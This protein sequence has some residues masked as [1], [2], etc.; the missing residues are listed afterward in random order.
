MPAIISGPIWVRP[1]VLG[2]TPPI[3]FNIMKRIFIGIPIE[4]E[5]QAE[6]LKLQEIIS[7]DLKKQDQA[8]QIR[9]VKPGNLHITLMPPWR[10]EERDI[11][12]IEQK[13]KT[14]NFKSFEIK[15]NKIEFGP[16]LHRPNLFW[17]KGELSKEILDFRQKIYKTLGQEPD[18]RPFFPHVTLARFKKENFIN[19]QKNNIII[20][21]SWSMQVKDFALY[22]SH[23][24]PNGADYTALAQFSLG[25]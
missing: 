10:I 4:K 7:T 14:I 12:D 6:I 25:N 11:F 22:E 9:G 23:L 13:L 2:L 20:Q 8:Y 17:L 21:I 3:I 15:F 5:I 1:E 16:S 18:A 24:L 19:I